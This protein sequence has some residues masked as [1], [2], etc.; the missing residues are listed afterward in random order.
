MSDNTTTDDSNTARGQ[1]LA[2]V[3]S[4]C[5]MVAALECDFDQLD[6]LKQE[7]E[8]LA[9]SLQDSID[10][11]DGEADAKRQELAEWDEA[12]AEELAE[13]VEAAG[14]WSDR[15]DV[16]EAIQQDPLSIEVRSGWGNPGEG[17]DAEEFRIVLCTGGPHVEILGELDHHGEPDRVRV[18]FRDWGTSGE[19]FDF[20][21]DAVLTYCQ[22][23]TYAV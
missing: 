16:Q 7:R 18:L 8:D 19:L 14:E 2:Q 17:L 20:D 12:N 15:D 5:A 1:A 10:G 22:Q 13:L 21:R 6:S 3:R 11:M 4:I 9:E 23:F